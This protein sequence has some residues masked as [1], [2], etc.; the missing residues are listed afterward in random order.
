VAKNA[1]LYYRKMIR[2]GT[3]SLNVRDHHMMDILKRLMRFHGTNA[4]S[5]VWAHNTHIGDARATD[6]KRAKMLNLGQLAREEAGRGNV[7]LTGFGTFMGTVVAARAWGEQMERMPV[8]PAIAG[9]WDQFLHENDNDN[10]KNKLLTFGDT[11]AVEDVYLDSKGQRAIGVVYHPEYEAVG[12]Y[13]DSILAERYDAFVFID[14]T[15]ALHPIHMP[16]SPDEEV[17][18]TFPTCV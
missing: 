5:I 15:H 1:E 8:P 9:S 14:K 3:T 10:G 7:M 2:G 13:V 18:E 4:K 6:M 11:K 12:N 17:P 16:L